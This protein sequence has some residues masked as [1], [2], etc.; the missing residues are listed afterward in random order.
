MTIA[1]KLKKMLDDAGRGSKTKLASYL[2]VPRNYP[3]RWIEYEDYGIPRD[4]ISQIAKFFNVT[5][6]YLLD[7]KQDEPTTRKIPLVGEASCGVPIEYYSDSLEYIDIP[8]TIY[9]KTMYA[10]TAQG[11]SMNPKISN[12]DIV[13]CD[14]DASVETGNIVHYSINGE[15]GIKKIKMNNAT[16]TLTLQPL[17]PSY[18]MIMYADDEIEKIKIARCIK[19]IA[20]L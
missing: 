12:G 20:S 11:D 1:E 17:N 13:I 4:K 9:N 19:V 3:T 16:G 5:T 2:G 8:A 14:L 7:D 18:D 15:S 10:V 6:D